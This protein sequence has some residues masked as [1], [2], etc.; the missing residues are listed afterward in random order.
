[1]DYNWILSKNGNINIINLTTQAFSIFGINVFLFS[2]ESLGRAWHTGYV[3]LNQ[4]TSPSPYLA[5]PTYQLLSV[6]AYSIYDFQIG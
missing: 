5:G 6:E 3:I 2:I 1:M 4:T